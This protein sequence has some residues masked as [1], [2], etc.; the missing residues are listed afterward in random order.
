MTTPKEN[1]HVVKRV[2]SHSKEALHNDERFQRVR[3]NWKDFTRAARYA[4]LMRTIM[5][6]IQQPLHD[7]SRHTMLTKVFF[8]LIKADKDAPPGQR[9]LKPEYMHLLTGIEL[10]TGIPL[11][12]FFTIDFSIFD[13]NMR[14]TI[15]YFDYTMLNP[16]INRKVLPHN[17]VDIEVNIGVAEID[18]GQLSFMHYQRS[19]GY[20]PVKGKKLS[21]LKI[22]TPAGQHIPEYLFIFLA[23]NCYDKDKQLITGAVTLIDVFD[24]RKHVEY[25]AAIKA[26]RIPIQEPYLATDTAAPPEMPVH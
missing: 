20:I 26:D 18:F 3:D 2:R 23:L 25:L 22:E 14:N 5:E 1:R 17:V 16:K 11:N 19:S 6:G 8:Q 12:D 13:Y 24:A 4:K 15:N 9:S 7:R 21:V 10:N